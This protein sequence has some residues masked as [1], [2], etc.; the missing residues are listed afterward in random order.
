MFHDTEYGLSPISLCFFK[1][2]GGIYFF[3]RF[4]SDQFRS[5]LI[6]KLIFSYEMIRFLLLFYVNISFFDSET[7]KSTMRSVSRFCLRTRRRFGGRLSI[8]SIQRELS[9]SEMH[10]EKLLYTML[11]NNQIKYLYIADL[12]LDY[13]TRNF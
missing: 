1:G 13:S 4:L 7:Q 8:L 10:T 9:T 12:I 3:C 5:D 11:L 2:G 6:N